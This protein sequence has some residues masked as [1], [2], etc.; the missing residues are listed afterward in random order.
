MVGGASAPAESSE[1]EV[2]EHP[3]PFWYRLAERICPGRCREIPEAVNPDRIVL[4]QVALW[5]RFAYLQQ[6]SSGEDFNFFHSHQWS[7]TI[8]IGLWGQ[9]VE[10][11]IA[12]P[13]RLRRAPYLYTMGADVVH[14]VDCPSPGHTSVFI[15]FFRD[16]DLK[17]YYPRE[18]R[19][20]WSEHIKVMVRRI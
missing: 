6:F 12:G 9:Y 7:R 14:R 3:K 10:E 11:R 1:G 15:G 8:A 20:L 13:L 17:H 4:R 16:D 5:K 2:N 18:G 19:R